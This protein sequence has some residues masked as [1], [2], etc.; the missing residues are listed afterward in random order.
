[1]S[2]TAVM[3]AG[4][5]PG[6]AGIRRPEDAFSARRLWSLGHYRAEAQNT[7][8]VHAIYDVPPEFLAAQIDAVFFDLMPCG[9]DRHAVA[10]REH[11]NGGA[12]SSAA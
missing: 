7:Q 6:G 12:G 2:A 4:S 1:M 8:G 9:E 11:R 5:T 10:G 3:I